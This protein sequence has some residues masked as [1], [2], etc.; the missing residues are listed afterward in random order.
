[1]VARCEKAELSDSLQLLPVRVAAATVITT[2]LALTV[3]FDDPG[4]V[5]R[6]RRLDEFSRQRKPD[7]RAQ[8]VSVL[9]GKIESIQ[10]GTG[11]NEQCERVSVRAPQ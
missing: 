5:L 7:L 9:R 3:E 1:M 2:S 6:Q 4:R 11:N 8:R 10:G